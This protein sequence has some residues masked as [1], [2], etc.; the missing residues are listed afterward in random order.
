MSTIAMSGCLLPHELDQAVGVARLTDDVVAPLAQQSGETF[1][2]AARRRRRSRPAVR[3]PVPTY[4]GVYAVR[5]SLAT[6][7]GTSTG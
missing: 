7:F 4:R 3:V 5:A 2:E 6:G 1:R